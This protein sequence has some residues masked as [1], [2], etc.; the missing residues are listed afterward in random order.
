L[1]AA[2][3]SLQEQKLPSV[4]LANLGSRVFDI[5]FQL[6]D[7]DQPQITCSVRKLLL[8][9]PTD[10]RIRRS[11]EN[12]D[13]GSNRTGKVLGLLSAFSAQ[14]TVDVCPV[15]MANVMA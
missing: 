6:T 7:Y 15:A 11:I 4:I 10:Q 13:T 5:L 1:K 12:A 3:S 8:L 2:Q 9:L 14:R